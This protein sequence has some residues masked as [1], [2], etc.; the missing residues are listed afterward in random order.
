LSATNDRLEV[1]IEELEDFSTAKCNDG[2]SEATITPTHDLTTGS[3]PK[4]FRAMAIP[5]AIGMVFNTLYS[6]VDTFFAGLISTDAQAGLSIASQVFFFLVAIGFGLSSSMGAL[7][8]NAYGEGSPNKAN[9][10]AQKGVIFGVLMSFVLTIIGLYLAPELI[11]LISTDSPYRSEANSYLNLLLLGVVFFLLGFGVNGILQARGDTK[12][13]TQAQIAAFFA[14]LFLNPLFI[15]GLLPGF[16]F[17]GLALSTLVSQAGVMIYM[18]Y[19]IY[20]AGIFEGVKYESLLKPD[21]Q[22]YKAILAQA[23]PSSFTMMVMII[24][25]F[26]IQFFLKDFGSQA[27]QCE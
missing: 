19:R 7:V 24:S 9:K 15:F 10:I 2:Y 20:R 8:G 11:E 5:M 22:I 21:W 16:G 6:V 18:L 23:I 17:D 27:L 13:M 14:N 25:G 4:H 1:R 12:S 3:I 26:V